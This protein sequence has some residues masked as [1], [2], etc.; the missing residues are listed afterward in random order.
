MLYAGRCC[1]VTGDTMSPR[2]A[3]LRAE[4]K[5]LK[6]GSPSHRDLEAFARRLGRQPR[7]KKT[8]DPVYVS[9][10]FPDL[11]VVTMPP[12]HSKG[13]AKGTKHAILKELLKDVERW[14]QREAEEAGN[15][16]G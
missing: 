13:L 4:W 8:G 14:E 11:Q 9:N 16:T 5:S 10:E 2:A 6:D 3:D 1:G 15:D 12:P 7:K